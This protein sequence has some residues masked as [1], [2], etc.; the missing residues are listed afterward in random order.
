MASYQIAIRQRVLYVFIITNLFTGSIF[1][2]IVSRPRLRDLWFHYAE[3]WVLPTKKV[4]LLAGGLFFLN[5]ATAYLVAYIKKWLHFPKFRLILAAVVIA[6]LPLLVWLNEPLPLLLQFFLFRI[7][8]V[9]LLTVALLVITQK[10]YWGITSLMLATAVASPL[11]GALP[12]AVFEFVSPEWFEIS[13]F[14]FSS[15]LLS[16]LFG[17]WLIKTTDQEFKFLYR[18]RSSFRQ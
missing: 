16:A 6:A 14:L 18:D 3:Y 9:L 10:W 12:Y 1:A 17:C 4:S 11:L 13:Q 2:W 15:V 5:L 8:L 7:V